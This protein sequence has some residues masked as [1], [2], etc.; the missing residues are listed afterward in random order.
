M[1]KSP[2]RASG[3]CERHSGTAGRIRLSTCMAWAWAW[4]G[5]APRKC[6]AKES[7]PFRKAASLS[8]CVLPL[9]CVS[10]R[11]WGKEP[12]NDRVKP[13]FHGQPVDSA[14]V[15]GY[16]VQ[17]FDPRTL[18]GSHRSMDG[19]AEPKSLCGQCAVEII[20]HTWTPGW[21]VRARLSHSR[22]AHRRRLS[23]CG[24][25][26]WLADHRRNAADGCKTWHD[27]SWGRVHSLLQA[28]HLARD[29]RQL[30]EGAPGRRN[31]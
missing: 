19:P 28:L 20:Q 17:H 22:A 15:E 12:R 8:G 1:A 16:W 23:R 25:P 5:Q 29:T 13:R 18:G 24:L 26:R 3:V 7:P 14:I 9:A 27:Q 30:R 4:A 10:T 11:L 2:E 6:T 21:R 31:A